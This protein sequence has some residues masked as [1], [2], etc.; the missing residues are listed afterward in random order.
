[1]RSA[2]HHDNIFS[3]TEKNVNTLKL[4]CTLVQALR[5]CTGRTAHRGSRGIAL[6]FLDHGTRRDEGSVSRPG[7]SLPPENT[8]YSLCR[9]LGGSQGR[10][11]QVRKISP[12]LGFDPRPVQPVASRYTVWANRPTFTSAKKLKCTLVQGLR[13]CTGRTAHRGSRSIALL[14]L[15]HGTRR[16]E[17][18]VPR[19]GSSL[20]PENTR[21]SLCRRLGGPQGRSGQVLKIS[22]PLGFDPRTFQPVAS[23]YTD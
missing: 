11:G 10:S 21:Y 2:E 9:R 20:P 22:P 5:L 4:N 3:D 17:G 15:D 13:L 23:R 16:G 8:R 7:R 14:F 6:L 18:S 1:M 12:Q 19:P